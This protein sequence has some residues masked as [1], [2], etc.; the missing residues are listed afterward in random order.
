MTFGRSP[1]LWYLVEIDKVSKWSLN[2]ARRCSRDVYFYEVVVVVNE[3]RP[4]LQNKK[5]R[6]SQVRWRLTSDG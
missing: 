3:I 4:R 2:R 6:P 1:A 5:P